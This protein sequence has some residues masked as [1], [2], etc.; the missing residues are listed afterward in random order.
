[1]GTAL[2]ESQIEELWRLADEP[3]LCFD[4]D[5][6]GQRAAGRAAERA[7]P[8]LRPGKS[9]RFAVVTGA[10][11]PDD[12]IRDQGVEAMRAV[13][14]AAR[15]LL[16][17]HWQR[18]IG[19][20]DL[21]TPERRAAVER[22]AFDLCAQISERSVQDHYRQ[23]FKER[24]WTLFRPAR[25]AP[26]S[27]GGGGYGGGVGRTGGGGR[28]AGRWVK[29]KWQADRPSLGRVGV[30]MGL[31]AQKSE[32]LHHQ[33]L[34]VTLISHPA[35]VDS[36][37]ERLG[38]LD[39]NDVALDRLRRGVLTTLG[40]DPTLDSGA[41][42]AHLRSL[43]LGEVL[44]TLM[45]SS[46]FTHAAFARPDADAQDALKGWDHTYALTRQKDLIADINQVVDRLGENPSQEDFDA[47]VVLKSHQRLGNDE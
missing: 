5:N 29:G 28:P 42:R 34:L 16:D 37:G 15:S 14:T 35:L 13:L 6:A 26:N 3:I 32:V 22:E 39:V 30:G 4:G 25:S 38:A 8:L 47:L 21:T 33:I 10:K 17:L 31:S 44:D 45:R 1:L 12:L 11:D 20:R 36:V 7:L 9:L 43:G 19:G 24:L 40:N 27:G 46:V 23:A 2:T 18:L 41:L